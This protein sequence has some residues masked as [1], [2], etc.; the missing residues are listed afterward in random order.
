MAV[1]IRAASLTQTSWFTSD[2]AYRCARASADA[3]CI[4]SGLA[5]TLAIT[6]SRDDRP[7]PAARLMPRR[8]SRPVP[9]ARSPAP[10]HYVGSGDRAAGTLRGDQ[11]E[12]GGGAGQGLE[13]I[14]EDKVWLVWWRFC[15]SISAEAAVPWQR[16][17][18]VGGAEGGRELGTGAR[19]ERARVGWRARG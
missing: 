4:A 9:A 16:A 8:A 14:V 1:A 3:P 7:S 15:C 2:D 5:A 18:L 12:A 10:N 6:S 19:A 11:E 13:G 17:A